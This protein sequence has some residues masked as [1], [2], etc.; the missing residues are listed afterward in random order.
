M[1]LQTSHFHSAHT[2]FQAQNLQEVTGIQGYLFSFIY[3]TRQTAPL[4]TTSQIESVHLTSLTSPHINV[5]TS[6]CSYTTPSLLSASSTTSMQPSVFS[7]SNL[8][9][10]TCTAH[11]KPAIARES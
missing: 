5:S 2:A 4:P 7:S 8:L 11:G 9:P 6:N 1:K 3:I 10:T